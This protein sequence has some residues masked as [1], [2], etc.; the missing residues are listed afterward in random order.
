[1][2]AGLAGETSRESIRRST[3]ELFGL[4]ATLSRTARIDREVATQRELLQADELGSFAGCEPDS[5]LERRGV[6]LRIGMPALLQRGDS[7][8]SATR[9]ALT[10]RGSCLAACCDE[11]NVVD[12]KTLGAGALERCR[13]DQLLPPD[14]RGGLI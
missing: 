14:R 4:G 12:L 13:A 6:L 10:S 11:A 9:W 3:P 2:D 5:R 1:M 8:K 7:E